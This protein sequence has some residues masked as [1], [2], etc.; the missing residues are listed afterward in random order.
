M[1]DP[2]FPLPEPVILWV[3]DL[4]VLPHSNP[5][6]IVDAEGRWEY[7]DNNPI[8]LRGYFASPNPREVERAAAA[9]VVVDGV[10]LVPN[11]SPVTVDDGLVYDTSTYRVALVRPNPSHTRVLLTR[12]DGTGPPWHFPET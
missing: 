5:S 8:P 1:T 6:A 11:G 12:V 9:G 3:H 10:A 2:L 4:S 7:A